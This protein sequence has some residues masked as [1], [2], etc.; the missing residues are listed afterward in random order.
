MRDAAHARGVKVLIGGLDLFEGKM[1]ARVS[2]GV[3]KDNLENPINGTDKLCQPWDL[4]KVGGKDYSKPWICVGPNMEPAH[5][6]SPGRTSGAGVW[7]QTP[8][9]WARRAGN[10]ELAALLELEDGVDMVIEVK[11]QRFCA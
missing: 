7:S 5:G 3:T 8:E 1:T 2:V 10:H 4:R 11:A 6:W 9:Q